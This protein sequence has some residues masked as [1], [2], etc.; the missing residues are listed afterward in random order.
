MERRLFIIRH[1][2]SSWDFD[3]LADVDRPLAKRGLRNAEEMAKRLMDKNL[4]PQLLLTSPA[5]RALYTALIMSRTWDLGPEQLQIRETLY[6]SSMKDIVKV[7]ASVS[8]EQTSLA[9][10]GHNPGFTAYGNTFLKFPLDNLPT[11]GV[12]VVT[13]DSKSWSGIGKKHV[14]ETYVDYPKR[15]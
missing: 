12:V 8:A 1:G 11:A 10:Y 5:S 2:K 13:L 14:K 9:I 6:T 4:V 15:K 3:G 7:V